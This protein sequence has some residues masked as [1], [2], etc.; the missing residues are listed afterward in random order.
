MGEKN[1]SDEEE[2]FEV[3]VLLEVLSSFFGDLDD[4]LRRR[5]RRGL[6]SLSAAI[7]AVANDDRLKAS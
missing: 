1:A 5:R 4:G 7:V 6:S 2:E 3:D